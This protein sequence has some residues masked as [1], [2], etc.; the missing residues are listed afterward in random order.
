MST[1]LSLELFQRPLSALLKKSDRA[2]TMP[3]WM[4]SSQRLLGGPD[5]DLDK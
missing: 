5:Q 3:W 4:K 1:T 2:V